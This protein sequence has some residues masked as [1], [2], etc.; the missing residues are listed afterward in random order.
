[1]DGED[2]VGLQVPGVLSSRGEVSSSSGCQQVSEMLRRG[3]FS[4]HLEHLA[5]LW[6]VLVLIM[7]AVGCVPSKS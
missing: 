1:M 3:R 5:Q 4:V 6:S 2:G 7:V